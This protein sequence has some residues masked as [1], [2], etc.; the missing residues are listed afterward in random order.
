MW[1]GQC[2]LG[3]SD[4]GLF[5]ITAYLE[6]KG[7]KGTVGKASVRFPSVIRLIILGVAEQFPAWG[8]GRW[9]T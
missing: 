3:R 4:L 8:G 2:I 9:Y 6:G 5:C 1:P 7:C